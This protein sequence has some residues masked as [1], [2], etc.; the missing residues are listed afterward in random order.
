MAC[1]AKRLL[2]RSAGPL[3]CALVATW[4]TTAL[5]SDLRLFT[6]DTL[7][8]NGD[9]RLVAVDGELS[10]VD[11]G[12]GKL[13]SGSN[14][15]LRVRPQLGNVNFIWQPRFTWSLS[16]TV[17]GSLQGGE[18]TEAGLSQAY[19]TFKPMRGSKVAFSARAGLMWPPVS[20]EHEGADWHVER[21]SR[22]RRSTAGSARK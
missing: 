13:R 4:P 2:V 18:R 19:L 5:A 1:A 12:L 20:L 21:A 8:I 16:A 11:G 3:G 17:V 15:D 7:E 14:G 9:L 10:W 22:P 6:P